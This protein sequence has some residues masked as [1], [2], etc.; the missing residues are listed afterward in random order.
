MVRRRRRIE[1]HDDAV[2]VLIENFRCGQHALPSADALVDAIQTVLSDD[3]L[4]AD[5]RR[6]A[7]ER[8]A[9]LRWDKIAEQ[10][11]DVVRDVGRCKQRGR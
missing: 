3:V 6:R 2:I 10:T 11:L 5:L 7:R 4:R 8:G 1:E 9:A